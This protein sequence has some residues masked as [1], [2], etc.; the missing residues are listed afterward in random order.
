MKLLTISEVAERLRV[1]KRTAYRLAQG[2]IRTEIGGS[3][4]VPEP[5]LDRYIAERTTDPCLASTSAAPSGGG[6][7]RTGRAGTAAN[8]SE[9][10][11]GK[12][13]GNGSELPSWL[14][15]IQ[16]RTVKRGR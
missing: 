12:S 2:M 13:R 15:P 7:T 5:A 1:S 14:R 6:T 9:R 10:R 16:P 11:T 3:L 4:R 8:L